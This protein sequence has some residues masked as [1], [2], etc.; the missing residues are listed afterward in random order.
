[1]DGVS[2]SFAV[3]VFSLVVGL[4]LFI[5]SG[6][7][8]HL[9][10]IGDHDMDIGGDADFSVDHDFSVDADVS[11]DHD[12]S[13]DHDVGGDTSDV[14]AHLSPI[15]PPI[16]STFLVG[17]GFCGML[18]EKAFHLPWFL[19]APSATGLS[20]GLAVAIF[21]VLGRLMESAQGTSHIALAD[22]IGSEGQ[23]ITPIP[24]NG[25]GEIAYSS[26]TGRSSMPARSESGVLIPKHSMVTIT[27]VIGNTAMVRET[28]D[29][30]LRGLSTEETDR[31]DE[32]STDVPQ[33]EAVQE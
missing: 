2:W 20:L 32:K 24:A 7:L 26:T 18:F 21:L 28:I 13:A 9:S 29:E 30:Q 27:Q 5:A 25:L 31:E 22:L 1:M 3:Y 23:V 12:F 10:G 8:G 33:E 19:S 4:G 14:G 6:L 16:M 11:A 15:S 17:F